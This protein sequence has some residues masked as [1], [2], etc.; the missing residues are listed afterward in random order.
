MLCSAM[1]IKRPFVLWCWLLGGVLAALALRL[2]L[3][4][5][6]LDT[7]NADQA[8]LGLMGKH[9]LGGHLFIYFWENKYCGAFIAYLAALNFKLFGMS[10]LSFKLATFPLVIVSI[11]FTCALANKLYG[12]ATAVLVCFIMAVSP[13]YVTLFSVS[14]HGT[15]AD[16]LAFGP[17]LLYL[18]YMIAGDNDNKR[19]FYLVPLLGLVSGMACWISPLITPYI[20]TASIVVF[21]D[22]RAAIKKHFLF[23]AVFFIIGAMP[24]I[25]FNIQ[26]PFATFL[27]LGSRPLD[28][29]KAVLNSDISS[30][31]QA[32]TFLKYI[33]SY[34]AGLPTAFLNTLL[35]IVGIFKLANPLS[36]KFRALHFI[37]CVSYLAPVIYFFFRMRKP[38]RENICIYLVITA[39]LFSFLSFL[40][41]PRFLL[42]LWPAV[43]ILTGECISEMSRH[44][45]FF[46]VLA[47]TT[48]LGI[49]LAGTVLLSRKAPP[50]FAGLAQ[51]LLAKD[52]K[53]GYADY[54]TAYPL[55]FLSGEKLVVSPALDPASIFPKSK[56][57]YPFYTNQVDARGDVFYVTNDAPQSLAQFDARMTAMRI[58]YR[59]D[60]FPPFIV[61]YS[62]SRRIY[63]AELGLTASVS[64][65]PGQ[66]FY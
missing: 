20:M 46:A 58:K 50:P 36:E 51:Y 30:Y 39:F 28:I 44:L 40:K 49:N 10:V 63:P 15:Y 11:G 65:I 2:L 1:N 25:V 42:P 32:G 57:S 59:K 55:M 31:G 4:L 52:L 43:A 22:N 35:A 9:I 8:V 27:N 24:M 29:S 17:V 54:W 7:V 53:W 34:V 62:F 33:R 19:A 14:P 21:K 47:L 18:A 64:G 66:L 5:T 3:L 37:L 26:H 61:Y 13:V 23:L 60:I 16:T 38:A 12:A 45:R 56:D 6:C 48:V 41:L